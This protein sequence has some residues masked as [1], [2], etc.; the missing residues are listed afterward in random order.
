MQINSHDKKNVLF[1]SICWRNG[2]FH[3]L[4]YH[5]VRMQKARE[6]CFGLKDEWDICAILEQP[7]PDLFVPLRQILPP[8]ITH[9]VRIDYNQ[10]EWQITWSPYKIR[11]IK[12]LELV[13]SSPFD[14]HHKYSNR[15]AVDALLRQ[16]KADDVL[17]CMDGKVKDTS[18][19]NVVFAEGEKS[20]KRFTPALPLLP[21]VKRAQLL[22]AGEIEEA[23]ITPTDLRLF[24][25]I[26]LI[27]AMID[28]GEVTCEL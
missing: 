17:I 1:E 26:Y 6:Q 3:L 14:Y 23:D 7:L 27:N 24:K 13:Y 28:L 18:Y 15:S 22:D 25:R 10:V 19:C 8:N 12:T 16:S 2:Q 11:P 20:K 5:T 9:K 21:G 4:D